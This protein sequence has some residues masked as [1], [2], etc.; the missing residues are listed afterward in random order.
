MKIFLVRH[1]T[2]D[3]TRKDIP[4]DIP[5]GPELT[6]KGEREAE[7]LAAFLKSRSVVKL[8]HSPLERAAGTAR[9]AAAL[10]VIPCVEEPRL[11]EWRLR[12]EGEPQVRER[13]KAVFDET[14]REALEAGAIGLVSHGGPIEVLLQE[15]GIDPRELAA[16]RTRFDTTNPL[17]PAGAWELE[18][19]G[20]ENSWGL[21]LVFIPSRG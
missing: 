17:P 18:R 1:A 12:E 21:K 7:E 2:P 8:Y 6:P 4:Y 14:F 13:M 16:C 10:N 20:K 19:D 3:W 9:I 5:P 15:L 11:A